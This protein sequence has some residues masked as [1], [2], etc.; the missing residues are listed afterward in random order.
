MN[1]GKFNSGWLTQ[2]EPATS[3][4]LFMGNHCSGELFIYLE[5]Q[6]Y[7]FSLPAT[8]CALLSYLKSSYFWVIRCD[9]TH[10]IKLILAFYRNKIIENKINKRFSFHNIY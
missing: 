5:G 7:I 8:V 2:M 1:R 3:Q 10:S 9:A 6:T 4:W